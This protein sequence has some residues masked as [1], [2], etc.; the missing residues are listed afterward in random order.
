MSINNIQTSGFDNESANT[1]VFSFAG[2]GK[3]QVVGFEW[4]NFFKWAIYIMK[5]KM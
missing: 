1:I 2:Q 3:A 4:V 5:I